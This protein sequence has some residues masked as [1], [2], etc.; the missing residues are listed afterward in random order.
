MKKIIMV[1]VLMILSGYALASSTTTTLANPYIPI[2]NGYVNGAMTVVNSA[3]QIAGGGA[4]PVVEYTWVLPDEDS[5]TPGTQIWPYAS[6]ERTDLYACVVLSDP[7]SLE[8]LADV[9]I[10]VYHPQGAPECGSKKYQKH[11]KVLNRSVDK[12]QIDECKT[13]ALNAGLITQAEFNDITYNVFDQNKYYMYKVNLTDNYC[14][15]AGLYEA[16][17]FAV[18][19][20]GSVAIPK[21]AWFTWVPSVILQIDFYNGV[22]YGNLIPGF[23]QV[24][25][26]D[27]DMSTP[28][29]PTLK[30]E[31][32]VPIEISVNNTKL[33]GNQ[34]HKEIA[35]F[36]SQFRSEYKQYLALDKLTFTKSQQLCQTDK[37]D[38]SVKAPLGTPVD[39][40]SGTITVSAA[41]GQYETNCDV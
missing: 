39:F 3:A 9:F 2:G 22:N 37:I 4:P 23:E 19:K 26:G 34:Y 24:V 41:Q 35:N 18:D 30:N 12:T 33:I 16:R 8:Y 7:Y 11:G 13:A 25:Q 38:F 1:A 40:Y 21:S 6:Q 36:D 5:A 10:D 17:T 32:N 28:N 27:A 29:A 31:G 20:A 15:P 14:Q